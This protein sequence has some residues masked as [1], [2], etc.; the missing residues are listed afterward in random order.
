MLWNVIKQKQLITEKNKIMPLK[1]QSIRK[2]MNIVVNGDKISKD[3]LI[4]ISEDWNETQENFFRKMLKQ[5]GHFRL[6]GV[7]Y[8]VELTKDSRTRS[9]GTKDSG[10]IQI[11]GDTQF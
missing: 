7:K 5:G 1:K 9:D 6:K 3:E 8:E 4:L 10:V 2:N 11:P